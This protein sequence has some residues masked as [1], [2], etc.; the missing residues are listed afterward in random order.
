MKFMN[1]QT[2]TP[3]FSLLDLL[4]QGALLRTVPGGQ[5]IRCEN[6]KY[7]VSGRG[8]NLRLGEEDFLLLFGEAKAVLH[9]AEQGLDEKKDEEYYAWR[10]KS[11]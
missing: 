8:A 10:E 6:G 9:M 5:L 1:L 4:F 2:P 11:Q 3:V 7:L